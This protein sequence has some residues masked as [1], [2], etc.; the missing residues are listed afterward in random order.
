MKIVLI[1]AGIAGGLFLLVALALRW[2]RRWINAPGSDLNRIY[3]ATM[4]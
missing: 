3:D 2:L 1:V 4:L